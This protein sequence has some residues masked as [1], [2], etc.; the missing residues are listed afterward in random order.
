[1][2]KIKGWRKSLETPY[3]LEYE[4]TEEL[5]V[6]EM[7]STIP[8]GSSVAF[9][10]DGAGEGWFTITSPEGSS[11]NNQP[12]KTK[13]KCNDAII[14]WMRNTR[15]VRMETKAYK[16]M[17][18]MTI[19]LSAYVYMDIV[20]IQAEDDEAADFIRDIFTDGWK[21]V[22]KEFPTVDKIDWGFLTLEMFYVTDEFVKVSEIL[23]MPIVEH[24][25]ELSDPDFDPERAKRE[26]KIKI[27]W[28]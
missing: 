19:T 16:A 13:K 1:M 9:I 26:S 24:T 7:G 5:F 20:Y 4:S 17:P 23:D 25:I 27:I 11:I 18:S 22:Q 14:E 2:G 6:P 8:E 21:G 10:K 28:K 3:H 15:T 12:F